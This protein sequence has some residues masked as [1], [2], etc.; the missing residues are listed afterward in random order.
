M[1]PSKSR[2][3]LR[4]TILAQIIDSAKEG[5]AKARILSLRKRFP[6]RAFEARN[7]IVWVTTGVEKG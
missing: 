2:K 7:A 3:G 1:G 5:L 6:E 4:Q